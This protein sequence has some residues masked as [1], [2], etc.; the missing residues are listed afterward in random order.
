MKKVLIGLLV[1][2]MVLSLTACSQ[3]LADLMGKM[4]NNVYG[5]PA[6]TSAADEAASKVSNSTSVE[7]DEDGNYVATVDFEA[8]ASITSSISTIKDS[9]A[10]TESLLTQ[11]SSPV[12]ADD[13]T[14]EEKA[15]V[16]TALS[17]QIDTILGDISKIEGVEESLVN[18]VTSALN[19]VKSSISDNPTKAELVTVAV[20]SEMATTVA[21]AKDADEALIA[22]GLEAYDTLKVISEVSSINVF[23]DLDINSL[24][25]SLSKDISRDDEE[26]NKFNPA[27]LSKTVNKILGMLCTDEKFDSAKYK[28]FIF[29]ASAIKSS[30]DLLTQGY[31]GNVNYLTSDLTKLNAKGFTLTVDDLVL[32]IV[33]S[34][35]SELDKLGTTV[36]SESNPVYL[37]PVVLGQLIDLNYG[38]L[39]NLAGSDLK[40]DFVLPEDPSTILTT[41]GLID[42]NID[43]KGISEESMVGE[44]AGDIIGNIMKEI[45]DDAKAVIANPVN[46]MFCKD[47]PVMIRT[48]AAMF[49]ESDWTSVLKTI[50]AKN[51]TIQE[52]LANKK[53]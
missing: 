18:E 49:V 12:V 9:P 41:L 39:S 32:Y 47:A 42:S 33:C 38:V 26:E 43:G 6:D 24:I 14:D 50:G 15:A 10:K 31:F 36:E 17:N 16:V 23:G 30:V 44:S 35:F 3:E 45:G 1:V 53:N 29:Q 46:T 52:L 40:H 21:Q 19:D 11:L 37:T 27:I 20:L 28:S 51:G 25:G 8:A 2:V 4:S 5:I 34:I 13:A 48:I 7:K 22:K